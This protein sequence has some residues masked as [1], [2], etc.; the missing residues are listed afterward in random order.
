MNKAA[1]FLV[2]LLFSS[3]IIISCSENKENI[4]Q[5]LA[6]LLPKTDEIGGWSVDDK[7]RVFKGEDLYHHI[8]GGAEIY[9]EYGFK[10][11]LVQDYVNENEQLIAVEIFEMNN[12]N[13]AYGMYSFKKGREGETMPVGNEGFL[14]SY[15]MNF[16]K[17]KYLFTL[18]GFDESE[19]TMNGL[20]ILAGA[21]DNNINETGHVPEIV[22]ILPESG[23][24][25]TSI[26]YFLGGLSLFNNYR[27]FPDDVFGFQEGVKADYKNEYCIYAFAYT[28][29]NTCSEK[30][31]LLSEKLKID[32]NFSE[33]SEHDG[34][35]SAVDANDR[36]LYVQSFDSFIFIVFNA[37]DRSNAEA[38][39][40]EMKS[41]NTSIR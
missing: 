20:R 22:K 13:S 3:L 41:S 15:Y 16:W 14:E 9:H 34:I 8:N 18:T 10:Q 37:K 25:R 6:S 5:N 7:P 39:M 23:L 32:T 30:F 24:V 26:K 36:T 1:P 11:I 19:E 29:N 28:D 33:V 27:F 21:I 35:I 4:E 2:I 12:D 31:T 40:N 17:G 38:V